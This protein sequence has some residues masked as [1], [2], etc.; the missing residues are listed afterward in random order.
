MVLLWQANDSY[1]PPFYKGKALPGADTKI[2]IVAMPEIR[3]GSLLD[4]LDDETYHGDYCESTCDINPT[5]YASKEYKSDS[6]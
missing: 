4:T 6:Y 3:S 2:K 5:L 1:V